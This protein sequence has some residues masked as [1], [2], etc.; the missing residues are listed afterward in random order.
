MAQRERLERLILEARVSNLA[1]LE[2][3]ARLGFK[4]IGRRVG[5]Y[6]SPKED[7]LILSLTLNEDTPAID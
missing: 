5:Y 2:L 4:G 3:Y 7:A 6:D 1:A